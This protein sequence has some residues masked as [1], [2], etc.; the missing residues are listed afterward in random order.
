MLQS[1]RRCSLAERFR[2]AWTRR[3]SHQ[4]QHRRSSSRRLT[5]D[6]LEL[7]ALLLPSTFTVVNTADNG[8]VNPAPLAGTGTL[9]Q[10]IID[11]DADPDPG[12][13]T[14]AFA[15]PGAGVQTIRPLSQLPSMTRPVLIDGYT[16]T[17]ASPNTLAASDNAVLCISSADQERPRPLAA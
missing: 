16:Q 6:W 2:G 13:D 11:A 10:A 14:I 15:I 8:G 7:E 9:R 3:S 17:G 5:L 12:V 4:T 1:P